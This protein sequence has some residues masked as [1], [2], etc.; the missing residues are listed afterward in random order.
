MVNTASSTIE[1][2]AAELDEHLLAHRISEQDAGVF[3]DALSNVATQ[4]G[5]D[6]SAKLPA[7]IAESLRSRLTQLCQKQFQ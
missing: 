3:L 5:L 7:D 2:L 6:G 1:D 4:T